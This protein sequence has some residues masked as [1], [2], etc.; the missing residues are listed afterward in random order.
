MGRAPTPGA[1]QRVSAH[2]VPKHK[3]PP[4][5]PSSPFSTDV[6]DLED[7]ATTLEPGWHDDPST[8]VEQAEA[9]ERIRALVGDAPAANPSAAYTTTGAMLD[10]STVDDSRQPNAS[11]LLTPPRL[12]SSAMLARLVVTSGN[13]TGKDVAVEP[14]K[15]YTIG[16]AV[17]N[18]LV[19]TDISVS[20]KHFDL[21]FE[22]SAWVIIDRG[23]GNGTLVNGNVEDRPFMLATGDAIEIGN[24]SF[25]FDIPNGA[26]RLHAHS[27]PAADLEPSTVAGKPMIPGD[28]D[29]A[30]DTPSRL[31]SV[32]VRAT[33]MPN[34]SQ[35][36]RPI[37]HLVPPAGAV[38]PRVSGPMSIAGTT[39]PLQKASDSVGQ[40]AGFG[41]AP[42]LPPPP[43]GR[44]LSSF[45]PSSPPLPASM[46][47][48]SASSLPPAPVGPIPGGPVPMQGPQGPTLL[49]QNLQAVVPVVP[50]P[51]APRASGMN[52]PTM[53]GDLMG[54]PLP[55]PGAIASP[56]PAPRW[57]DP[58]PMPHGSLPPQGF[59]PY[60]SERPSPANAMM[61]SIANAPKD[62]T[63]RVQPTPF[64][65]GALAMPVAA[66]AKKPLMSRQTMLI[67]GGA[68]LTVVAALATILIIRT[69]TKPSKRTV[70][71]SETRSVT[72]QDQLR[73]A[74]SGDETRPARPTQD[75]DSRRGSDVEPALADNPGVD[76]EKQVAAPPAVEPGATTP[77]VVPEDREKIED[78]ENKPAIAPDGRKDTGRLRDSGRARDTGR[79]R[80][81][82]RGRETTKKDP[83]ETRVAVADA[84]GARA[85][86]EQL[87]RAKNFT[88]ASST[89]RAAAGSADA[90]EATDLKTLAAAYEKFGRLYN[91]GM[92]EGTSTKDAWAA[93]NKAKSYD[94]GAGSE[95]ASEIDARLAK[96]APKA[97]VTFMAARDFLG[98]KRAVALAEAA[99]NKNATTES[100]RASLE[101]RAGEL[102]KQAQAELSSD[103][104]S[105]KQKLKQ[106]QSLVDPKSP[107]HQ[108][109]GKLLSDAG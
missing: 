43:D 65:G 76:V 50:N 94:N 108:K 14:G 78:R 4:G 70:A 11:M 27:S 17:D 32:P 19:L 68:A 1:P 3:A 84:S 62:Q 28:E 89:L 26:P 106:A 102:V 25:R 9:A 95:F 85:K 90:D 34:G 77:P 88:A 29:D 79:S 51:S 61:L 75:E 69:T 45:G 100:V 47:P 33:T 18:D 91:L 40:A 31:P 58:A 41:A 101:Q 66:F 109:A 13:D 99:G 105:A 37:P 103:P 72:K 48:H 60:V 104:G 54:M 52:A 49:A 74:I 55:A 93:L 80:D 83:K 71:P 92:A 44:A 35:R 15:T 86:A 82:G 10:E 8:T 20:R 12:P 81:T 21:R 107:W 42:S 39:I 97:A 30:V 73:S 63:A 59:P 5:P 16:R 2:V 67:I 38:P 22:G 87:Y 23:S 56:A 46:S 57:N 98:A 36:P 53:L 6:P 96:I 24:T 7:Q 64:G